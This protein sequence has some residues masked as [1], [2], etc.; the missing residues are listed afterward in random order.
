[1][2]L[3]YEIKILCFLCTHSTAFDSGIPSYIRYS[4]GTKDVPDSTSKVNITPQNPRYP[5]HDSLYARSLVLEADDHYLYINR[6]CL[7]HGPIDP[8]VGVLK[9]A[10]HPDDPR[11]AD[12]ALI[13][14]MGKLLS[15]Y[16][17]ADAAVG[18]RFDQIS[19][20]M[21]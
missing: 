20:R 4:D 7:I 11:P 3:Y 18:L 14:R 19:S 5:V 6:D 2:T 9:F 13:D 10:A 16:I 1:M 15:P 8:S 17:A 21:L 12:Y